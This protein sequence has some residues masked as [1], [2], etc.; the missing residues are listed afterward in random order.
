[1]NEVISHCCQN[2]TPKGQAIEYH[3]GSLSYFQNKATSTTSWEVALGLSFGKIAWEATSPTMRESYRT[4]VSGA[5]IEALA[6]FSVVFA[7]LIF[8]RDDLFKWIEDRNGNATFKS[9]VELL[10]DQIVSWRQPG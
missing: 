5:P 3:A 2:P 8:A 7:A 4:L 6:E 1:M 10:S 9:R